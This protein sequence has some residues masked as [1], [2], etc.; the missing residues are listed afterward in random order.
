MQPI[1]E[2]GAGVTTGGAVSALTGATGSGVGRI[3]SWANCDGG[4]ACRSDFVSFVVATFGVCVGGGG[5]EID[6]HNKHLL[7]EP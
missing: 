3:S 1:G 5:E 2:L 7:S 6:M 4:V